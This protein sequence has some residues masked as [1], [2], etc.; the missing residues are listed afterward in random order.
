MITQVKCEHRPVVIQ[1]RLQCGFETVFQ[2]GDRLTASMS[3]LQNGIPVLMVLAGN[4]Q[5]HWIPEEVTHAQN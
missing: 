3:G 1:R 4:G 5:D 2:P